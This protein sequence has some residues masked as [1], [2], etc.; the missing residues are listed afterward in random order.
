MEDKKLLTP[1]EIREHL[2]QYVIGQEDAKK[3]LAV[4]IYNHYK[5]IDYSAAGGVEIKKSNIMMIG[6]TGSGK[7]HIVTTLAKMLG[8]PFFMADATML[9]NSPS[10]AG[11]IDKMMDGL[12]KAANGDAK[13]ASRG[14][15]FIDEIDKLVTG[16]NKM[17]GETIQQA[18][19]KTIEGTVTPKIDTNN[20]LFIVG[21]AFVNLSAIVQIRMG[22]TKAGL[23]SETEL[24]KQ[25]LPDD[26]NKFGLIPEFVGRIPVIVPLTALC[27]A[28]L[29]EILTKPKN[30]IVTQ[31]QKMLEIDGIEL[32][33]EDE[34]LEKIAEAAIALKTGARALR[35]IVEERMRD[36]MYE[37]PGK[38]NVNK[39]IIT[40][41]T[42]EKTGQPIIE[43]MESGEQIEIE[44][45]VPKPSRP[46]SASE[47]Y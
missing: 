39:I 23:L 29:I 9:V 33:F 2:D 32:E 3:V 21:G 34:A 15:I 18:L 14:I 16:I 38:T 43:Y 42:I 28:S 41:A 24:V 26:L 5:R 13:L 36:I 6:P 31:Y 10:I 4:A 44:P 22:D 40:P 47:D 8:V 46:I 11:E 37:I 12:I 25:A 30:A 1:A 45:L 35:T 17:R 20:I 19:L 7:T 27:R